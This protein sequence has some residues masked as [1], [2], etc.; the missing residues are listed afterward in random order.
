MIPHWYWESF[1]YASNSVAQYS[2]NGEW[3]DRL[4]RWGCVFRLRRISR[5]RESSGKA[6]GSS[7]STAA[8]EILECRQLFAAMP[9]KLIDVTGNPDPGT[10]VFDSSAQINAKG[11]V[12]FIASTGFYGS[13]NFGLFVES[14]A[15]AVTRVVSD[16][17]AV[18]GLAKTTFAGI[19]PEVPFYT[20]TDGGDVVFEA[21][22]SPAGST[23]YREGIFEWSPTGGIKTLAAT[24]SAAPGTKSRNFDVSSGA[25]SPAVADASGDVAFT[26]QLQAKNG[27]LGSGVW[28]FGPSGNLIGLAL[29]GNPAPGGGVFADQFSP[30]AISSSGRIAFW[31]NNVNLYEGDGHGH[32]TYLKTG[33]K[34]VYEGLFFSRGA[35]T[36]DNAGVVAFTYDSDGPGNQTIAGVYEMSSR[37]E[38]RKQLPHRFKKRRA[39]APCSAIFRIPR[40][41]AMARWR[42]RLPSPTAALSTVRTTP[43]SG[44]PMPAA[45]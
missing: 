4:N 2:D 38:A 33:L 23:N 40:S 24:G 11:Q 19:A 13:G 31:N 20:L 45:R 17:M 14:P 1:L 37:P 35:P 22:L 15:G 44:E 36:I 27:L 18:P 29:G 9:L 28:E 12:A 39:P 32:F 42:S 25:F 16:G 10:V 7:R 43:A 21:G 41:R 30:P 34:P 6:A 5:N 26:G 8:I 3:M